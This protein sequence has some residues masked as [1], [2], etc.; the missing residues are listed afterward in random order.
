MKVKKNALL[1]RPPLPRELR[2]GYL[3]VQVPLNLGYLASVIQAEGIEPQ[4]ID[5][6]VLPYA[7]F[8]LLRLIEVKQPL[9]V[10]FTCASCSVGFA[11]YIASKIKKSFPSTFVILGGPH[12][13]A[14]AEDTLREFGAFDAIVIG[15]GEQ[16]LKE[17]CQVLL[18]GRDFSQIPGLAYRSNKDEIKITPSRALISDLDTLDFKVHRFFNHRDYACNHVTRGFSRRFLR[19]A[20]LLTM[21]GCPYQCIFCASHLAYGNTIRFRSI[22][23]IAEEI[24]FLKD[25]FDIQHISIEDDTF[26]LN[27][28][29]VIELGSYMK[30]KNINW[31]CNARV[32]EVNPSLITHMVKNNCQKI[33]F[34]IESGSPRIL[35]LVKKGIN[36]EQIYDAFSCARKAKLRYL[37]ANFMLGS[38]PEE[39]EED[40]IKTKELIYKLRPDFLT[41]T[42][43]CP[44]PG[45][46]IYSLLKKNVFLKKNW[47]C[48]HLVSSQLPYSGLF[49]LSAEKLIFYRN[50]LLS[51]YYTCPQY[52]LK[53][54]F[55]LRKISELKYFM[56]LAK[57][58]ILT[59]RCHPR[60]R[61]KENF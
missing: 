13:S 40:I 4:I 44:F 8:Q 7:S 9:F 53:R 1:I 26:T 33:A 22:K 60:A 6:N 51:E 15:E 59:Q 43:M 5:Y 57:S 52:F 25:E 49:H 61:L 29:L 3:S 42:V 11:G 23:H 56:H 35:N 30:K 37:E 47:M 55:N 41:L 32:N 27:H 12:A 58:L 31:N 21:R 24:S 28:R 50:S 45:T 17:I 48:Y 39:K 54:I 38:H 18:A 20:E 16:T 34:G 14:S 36:L 10:G 19:I 46:E 2:K